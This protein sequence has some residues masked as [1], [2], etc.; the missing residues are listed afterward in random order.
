MNPINFK[1]ANLVLARNQSQYRQL[2]VHHIKEST[3]GIIISKWSFTDDEIDYI[4]KNKSMYI[5]MM[6]FGNNP[7]PILPI[8]E[9][10]FNTDETPIKE[11][12]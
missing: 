2:P 12:E 10:L 5:S 11:D 7:M 3:E 1:Q 9:E 6:T 8:A 4:N